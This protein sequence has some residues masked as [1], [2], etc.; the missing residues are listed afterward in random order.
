MDNSSPLTTKC[1]NHIYSREEDENKELSRLDSVFQMADLTLKV[2][3]RKLY[4]TQEEFKQISVVF[5]K[6]LSD[7]FVEKQK[8]EINFTGKDYKTFVKF[9][10]V[11][12]PGLQDPFDGEL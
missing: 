4:V 2:G 10:R 9:I 12:H 5:E 3:N 1:E 6:M 7:D 11:A 8:Q